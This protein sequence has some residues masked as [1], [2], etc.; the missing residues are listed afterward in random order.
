M[1]LLVGVVVLGV[2]FFEKVRRHRDH[3][4][5]LPRSA[6]PL[7]RKTLIAR[8]LPSICTEHLWQLLMISCAMPSAHRAQPV[9]HHISTC[10]KAAGRFV[11]DEP[12][13]KLKYRRDVVRRRYAVDG[14]RA[15]LGWNIENFSNQ[16]STQCH[17]EMRPIHEVGDL[18]G[19]CEIT[20]SWT[21]CLFF[22]NHLQGT[23]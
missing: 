22:A 6:I 21:R 2:E 12:D 3:Q 1:F 10:K 8:S 7:T 18:Q 19:Y 5:H 4:D 23:S 17:V 16:T 14:K 13:T 11:V 15:K 20:E 9:R